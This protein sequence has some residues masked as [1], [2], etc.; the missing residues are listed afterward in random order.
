MGDSDASE[1]FTVIIALRLPGT[2]TVMS[3]VR[4]AVRFPGPYC[5]V[6][7]LDVRL[8]A[9]LWATAYQGTLPAVK[10]A[11]SSSI[12]I[13]S[14]KFVVTLF[15]RFAATAPLV[16]SRTS[17]ELLTVDIVIFAVKFVVT[18]P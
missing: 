15:E 10:F 12:E 17:K 18:S 11:S 4:F 2:N 5:T 9:K 13:I 7:F 3:L 8:S 16:V 6:T 1:M 14:E